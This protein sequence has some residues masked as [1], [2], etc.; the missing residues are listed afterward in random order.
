[1]QKKA[2]AKQAVVAHQA[3]TGE[4][5]YDECKMA[6]HDQRPASPRVPRCFSN[7]QAPEKYKRINC[8]AV[9]NRTAGTLRTMRSSRMPE[10]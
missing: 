2:K 10:R 7:R 9:L 8:G 1:V 6:E 4:Q 3:Q 5:L